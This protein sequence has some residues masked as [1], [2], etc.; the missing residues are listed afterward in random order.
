MKKKLLTPIFLILL[1][2]LTISAFTPLS[3]AQKEQPKIVNLSIIIDSSIHFDNLASWLNTVNANFTFCIW[4]GVEDDI[5]N[6][7][8]RINILKAHGEITPRLTYAQEQTPENRILEIDAILDKY[9]NALG[10]MP[11]GIYDFVPDTLTAQYLEA[12]G[13]IYYQGYCFDQYK[14]DYMTMRGGFQMPYYASAEHILIPSDTQDIVILPHASW[15]WI[16]S[17]TVTHNIQ[18]HP[19]NLIERVGFDEIQAE[20]YF[21]SMIDNSLEGSTPFGYVMVQFEWE[22]CYNEGVTVEAGNWINTLTA[23]DYTFQTCEQTATWFRE[24]YPST[25]TY[26]IDFVSPY[27]NERI[28]WFFN[29]TCRIARIDNQ[30]VSYVDYRNQSID[31]FLITG[32]GIDW[33]SPSSETNSIDISLAFKIDDLGGAIDRHPITTNSYTF[34]GDL[35]RFPSAFTYVEALLIIYVSACFLL[36]VQ[37]FLRPINAKA[38]LITNLKLANYFFLGYRKKVISPIQN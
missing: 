27:N 5:F 26:R 35:R 34:T 21:F 30:V 2:A 25:P 36:S 28:E 10:V 12:R 32:K 23:M 14:I 19:F 15:D 24:N 3:L 4:E 31:A 11:K 33:S 7:A 8:T 13:L 37:N 20:N 9:T 22:W 17:F 18:L 16:A 29:T 1:A 6:N 38:K